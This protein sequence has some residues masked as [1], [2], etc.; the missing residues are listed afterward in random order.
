MPAGADLLVTDHNCQNAYS[1]QVKT[2]AKPA[3]FW[4]VGE[5]AKHLVSPTHIYV[6]VNLRP[7]DGRHEYFVVP[8]AI[9]A[10]KTRVS[11]RKNSTWY[12][13]NKRDAQSYRDAW[14]VVGAKS[15]GAT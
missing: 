6:F 12:E 3:S 15:S 1:I 2:N 11:L 7:K 13:F 9:V 10:E 8:S 4:L 5:K 14:A